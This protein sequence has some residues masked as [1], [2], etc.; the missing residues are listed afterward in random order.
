MA[1]APGQFGS[2]PYSAEWR[3]TKESREYNP[4]GY[5]E[6]LSS[7]GESGGFEFR[8]RPKFGGIESGLRVPGGAIEQSRRIAEKRFNEAVQIEEWKRGGWSYEPGLLSEGESRLA[9]VYEPIGGTQVSAG[10]KHGKKLEAELARVRKISEF[11]IKRG[12]M[13]EAAPG[14][15]MVE[16]MMQAAQNRQA[17]VDIGFRFTGTRHRMGVQAM[18]GGEVI[19]LPFEF[20]Q[21]MVS[22]RSKLYGAAAHRTVD[23]ITKSFSEYVGYR[24]ART[25]ETSETPMTVAGDIKRELMALSQEG[26]FTPQTFLGTELT[27]RALKDARSVIFDPQHRLSRRLRG[28]KAKVVEMQKISGKNLPEAQRMME[29]EIYPEYK[30]LVADLPEGL[31]ITGVK[32]EHLFNLKD[33]LYRNIMGSMVALRDEPVLAGIKWA[34]LDKGIHQAWQRETISPGLPQRLGF[35]RSRPYLGGRG[36]IPNYEV[37][38]NIGYLRGRWGTKVLGDAQILLGSEQA[39]RLAGEFPEQRVLKL[40]VASRVTDVGTQEIERRTSPW[41]NALLERRDVRRALNQGREWT[42]SEFPGGV[43]IPGVSRR[44]RRKGLYIG[45]STGFAAASGPSGRVTTGQDVIL[46]KG[47][48]ISG[49]RRMETTQGVVYEIATA[50]KKG[51]ASLG[52]KGFLL[53]GLQRASAGGS[54]RMKGVDILARIQEMKT[55]FAQNTSLVNQ[56]FDIAGDIALNDKDRRKIHAKLAGF[57]ELTPETRQGGTMVYTGEN[58]FRVSKEQAKRARRFLTKLAYTRGGEEA[59]RKLR[60]QFFGEKRALTMEEAMD[61]AYHS[62]YVDKK[63]RL[64]TQGKEFVRWATRHPSLRVF[65]SSPVSVRSATSAG[66]KGMRLRL[67]HYWAMMARVGASPSADADYLAHARTIK[68]LIEESNPQLIQ[69]AKNIYGPMFESFA[70]GPVGD[71][72]GVGQEYRDLFKAPVPPAKRGGVTLADVSAT[73]LGHKTGVFVSL[74][75][76]IQQWMGDPKDFGI[77]TTPEWYGTNRLWIPSAEM[78]GVRQTRSGVV[79]GDKT[80]AKHMRALDELLRQDK[81]DLQAIELEYNRLTMHVRG[82]MFS[83]KGRV[84]PSV[85]PGGIGFGSAQSQLMHLP[86]DDT[87]ENAMDIH[88]TYKKAKRLFG[89]SPEGKQLLKK[90]MR[91]QDVFVSGGVEPLMFEGHYVP[92]MRARLMKNKDMIRHIQSAGITANVNDAV[93]VGEGI[94]L[95]GE[96]DFDLDTFYNWAV[97]SS[98]EQARLGRMWRRELAYYRFARE[99]ATKYKSVPKDTGLASAILPTEQDL[100]TM[101][102]AVDEAGQFVEFARVK[103]AT[104]VPELFYRTRSE[105]ATMM[106]ANLAG[107]LDPSN[108]KKLRAMGLGDLVEGGSY[109]AHSQAASMRAVAAMTRQQ[110]LGKDRT[111]S[112][113]IMTQGLAVANRNPAEIKKLNVAIREE[114]LRLLRGSEKFRLGMMGEPIIARMIREGLTDEQ[115]ASQVARDATEA[116]Q[117]IEPIVAER[118][119]DPFHAAYRGVTRRKNKHQIARAFVEELVEGSPDS[120]RLMKFAAIQGMPRSITASEASKAGLQNIIDAAKTEADIKGAVGRVTSATS[121]FVKKIWG[122]GWAG[123]A[124]LVGGA[125]VGFLGL[126]SALTGPEAVAPTEATPMPQLGLPEFPEMGDLYSAIG[127]TPIMGPNPGALPTPSGWS[128][129]MHFEDNLSIEQEAIVGNILGESSGYGYNVYDNL[130]VSEHTM[131]RYIRDKSR[132]DF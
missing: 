51:T 61:I 10:F 105:L 122:S 17:A 52:I 48:G 83:K 59:R 21:G 113:E 91:G 70:K 78:V 65:R 22:R 18:V 124:A 84:T 54:V 132:S 86:L 14:L 13:R 76:E 98:D 99:V 120:E 112:F 43:Y 33:D 55:P 92:A 6:T 96:R 42:A 1:R 100:K 60:K 15:T 72:V 108:V 3:L 49:I 88:M 24:L 2:I 8:E 56:W 7:K 131:E 123:K 129:K 67:E 64:S 32:H 66:R 75:G 97:H 80:A 104:P 68:K 50:R 20:Q 116:M 47:F 5:L 35:K 107:E 94:V 63:G 114:M 85:R 93:R 9:P 28:L 34:R 110:F 73:A 118:R 40:H 125:A 128:G 41:F 89:N 109:L 115:I 58:D 31:T 95:I 25:I 45:Q 53:P 37:P 103:F 81:P 39:L 36:V 12:G 16:Q 101:R 23:D 69:E 111:R 44:V 30:R 121:Q 19:D 71:V 4:Y 46:R 38:M 87:A 102:G 57:L 82:R 11:G 126:R 119:T 77:A 29:Q 127:Q 27:S 62:Q 117:L 26:Y 130:P 74:P 90:L 79:F 106:T